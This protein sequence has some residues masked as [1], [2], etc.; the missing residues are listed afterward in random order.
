MHNKG[1][2]DYQTFFVPFIESIDANQY[3]IAAGSVE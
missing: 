2:R 3:S 1:Q